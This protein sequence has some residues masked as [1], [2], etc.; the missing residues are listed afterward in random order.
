MIVYFTDDC[1]RSDGLIEIWNL[2]SKRIMLSVDAHDGS[3]V[4]AIGSV[5]G[6]YF[7]R[8]SVRIALR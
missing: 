3:A 4:N 2:D 5:Y 6:E 7:Y 1:S 8:Y